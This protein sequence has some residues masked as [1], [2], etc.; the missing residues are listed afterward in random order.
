MANN[1]DWTS[2]SGYKIATVESGVGGGVTAHMQQVVVQSGLVNVSGGP[3]GVSG[4][5]T[6]IVSAGWPI[7]VTG[8]VTA[9]V[10]IVTAEVKG[11]LTAQVASRPVANVVWGHVTAIAGLAD[12]QIIGA[13][14]AGTGMFVTQVTIT[15]ANGSTGTHVYLKNGTSAVWAVWCEMSGGGAAVSFAGQPLPISANSALNAACTVSAT[16]DVAAIGWREAM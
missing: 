7:G 11:T 8:Q 2:G 9:Q 10:G 6:G 5:V 12:T 13:Q 14:G 4:A 1:L 3:V 15:N 16:V